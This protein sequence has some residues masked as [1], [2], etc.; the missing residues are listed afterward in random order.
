MSSIFTAGV[1]AL[2]M[3]RTLTPTQRH[4]RRN[5]HLIVGGVAALAGLGAGAAAVYGG[6]AARLQA[7]AKGKTWMANLSTIN[8]LMATPGGLL[9]TEARFNQAG[10]L[11]IIESEPVTPALTATPAAQVAITYKDANALA[12]A[13]EGGT[14][15]RAV[16]SVI[17]DYEHWPGTPLEQQQDSAAYA[18]AASVACHTAPKPVSFIAAPSPSIVVALGA[19]EGPTMYDT[20]LA[21]GLA[22]AAARYADGVVIQAQQLEGNPSRYLSWT[23][24]FILQAKLANPYVKCYVTLSG[25]PNGKALSSETLYGL[26]LSVAQIVDGYWLFVPITAAEPQVGVVPSGAQATEVSAQQQIVAM[27]G[28]LS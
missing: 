27:L 1:S 8:S 26:A 11:T 24:S 22:G 19:A 18:E 25:A 4:R 17:W 5:E 2:V 23:R 21:L 13:V 16:T 6:S 14:L 20:F 7:L 3:D 15:N 12:A 9:P 28:S 10:S